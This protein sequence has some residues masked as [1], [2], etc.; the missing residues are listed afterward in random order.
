VS[1]YY[2]RRQKMGDKILHRKERLILTTIDVINEMGIQSLST[3]EIAKRQGVSEATLFRHFKSKN[4]LLIA[5]LDF[6]SKFDSDIAESI[7]LKQLSPRES[8]EF[9]VNSYVEYYENYPAITSIMQIY[10]VL[11]SD[12]LLVDKIKSILNF[13]SNI[14]IQ[15]FDNAKAAGAIAPEADSKKLTD[16]ISGYIRIN[17]FNWRLAGFSYSLKDSTMSSLKMILDAFKPKFN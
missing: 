3:R 1:V 2:V 11:A 8:I 4:E 10:E 9:W 6:Y 15:L 14:L 12:N 13:R 7:N 5:V 17:C 16:T